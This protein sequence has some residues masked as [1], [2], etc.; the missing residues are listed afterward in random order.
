VKRV[1]VTGGAGFIGSNLVFHLLEHQ[2]GI[3]VVNL[4]ALTY[5]GSAMNLEGLPDSSRHTFVRG[6]IADRPLV[7]RL[8]REERIDTIVHLAAETHVDRSIVGPAAF[9]QTNLVGTFELLEAAREVWLLEGAVPPDETRFHHVS[10][11]EVFG[12]LE[13]EDPPF[14]EDHLYRPNSPYAASKA[15]SDHLVRAYAMTY[16][17]R[18]TLSN[19]SNNYGARQFPEK[20]IPL[21][22]MNAVEGKPLPLY[23]DG[24]Q[25]RDWI[26]VDDHC[27]ALAAILRYGRPGAAYNVGGGNQVTNLDL[28]H[29]LCTVLDGAIPQSPHR[30][31]EHLVAF[32]P[33]RP[34][35]DRRYAMDIKKIRSELRWEPRETLE[36]GLRKTVAWYL[37]NPDWVAAIREQPTYREWLDRNYAERRAMP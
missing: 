27:E 34:G 28:V 12:A 23:G 29:T 9:I 10:T 1:L 24:M 26:Y 17:L 4:D 3:H 5:A 2:P 21:L 13:P 7:K 31:H 16:G 6:D 15:G 22:I 19:C 18:V 8:L 11:D 37:A 30:P 25:I 14:T 20:L 33:D 32:V 36:S 35:H